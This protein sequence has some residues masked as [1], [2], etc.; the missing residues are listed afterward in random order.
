MLQLLKRSDGPSLPVIT[1]DDDPGLRGRFDRVRATMGPVG[2]A[3]IEYSHFSLPMSAF[4]ELEY[5][6]DVMADPGW[7]RMQGGV[8]LRYIF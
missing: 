5:F 1:S 3:G 8:G 2:V 7:T 4:M 6:S